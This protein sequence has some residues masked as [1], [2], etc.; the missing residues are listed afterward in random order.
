MEKEIYIVVAVDLNNGIGKKGQL[1]WHFSKELKYFAK[2]SS[3][4]KDPSKQNMLIMG[5]STWE[6]I[7][8]NYR[9]LPNRKNVV[10]TRNQDY[11]AD[12]AHI[13]HSLEEALEQAD[14]QIAKVFIIGGAKV[15]QEMVDDPIIKGI[16]LT[17]IHETFDCDTFFPEIP[18]HFKAKSLG[19]DSEKGIE[20]EYLLYT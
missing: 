18:T 3:E 6:S 14:E 4:T 20:F 17:R 12:G 7:P 1:P 9:P 10:L 16:Y 5:R 15:F 13:V 11:D 2:L 19:S 8:E